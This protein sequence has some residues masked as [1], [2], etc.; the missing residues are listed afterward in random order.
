MLKLSAIA[1]SDS[2]FMSGGMVVAS[3][4]SGFNSDG[5]VRMNLYVYVHIVPKTGPLST[6][7]SCS[8]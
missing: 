2:E 6:R 4:Y 3:V 1:N 7:F 5:C 8:I